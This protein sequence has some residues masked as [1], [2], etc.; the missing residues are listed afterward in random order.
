M[1]AGIDV[2]IM[3]ALADYCKDDSRLLNSY[4]GVNINIV[5]Q[6]GETISI[7]PDGTLLGMIDDYQFSVR[8]QSF[9]VL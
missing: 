1:L 5:E 8:V 2:K 9:W 3:L 6:V 4:E 7:F